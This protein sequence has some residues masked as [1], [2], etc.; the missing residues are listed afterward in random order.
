MNVPPNELLSVYVPPNVM[1]S[2][3]LITCYADLGQVVQ[4]PLIS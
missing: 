4:V 2:T 1:P 3:L